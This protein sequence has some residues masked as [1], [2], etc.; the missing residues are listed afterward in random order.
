MQVDWLLY[1]E[2]LDEYD[3]VYRQPHLIHV[4]VG[5][6]VVITMAIEWNKGH[7]SH[8]TLLYVVLHLACSHV[9]HNLWIKDTWGGCRKFHTAVYKT[10]PINVLWR[11]IECRL[12][13]IHCT[14]TCIH[15]Y[16]Q[17]TYTF[18]MYV[19]VCN[20]E[21]LTEWY[22][23]HQHQDFCNSPFSLPPK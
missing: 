23:E 2:A 1:H 14:C 7:F 16:V 8:L 20:I 15:R 13:H 12:L 5:P 18:G 6:M 21:M 19:L 22:N 10:D 9:L 17:C 11:F 4:S 3:R